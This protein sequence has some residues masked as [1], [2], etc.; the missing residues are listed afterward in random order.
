[1]QF[2]GPRRVVVA[3]PAASLSACVPGAG[4]LT[5]PFHVR[6]DSSPHCSPQTTIA[7]MKNQW[8][9]WFGGAE[10]CATLT[11]SADKKAIP[12]AALV[13]LL[14]ATLSSSGC[15]GLTGATKPASNQQSTPGAAAISVAPSSVSFGR[16]ALGSTASQSV[17]ISNGGGS[18]LT[19]T[20]ASTTAAGVNITGISLPIVI[21]AGKQSTFDVVFSPK[22]AGALSGNITVMSDLS[23][24]PSM[25]SL[26][27][28]GMA[29]TA[30]LT[31]SASSLSFGNVGVGKS[32]TLSVTLTNAGNSN[33][34]VSTVSVSGAR[35]STNGV[36][37]GLILAPGQSA[38]L[39][40]T[41]SPVA[42]GSLPGSVAVA[43]NA[44]NSPATI[45]LL[46]DGAA[47]APQTVSHSVSLT[48]T[49]SSSAVAGYDVYRS[50]VSGGPYS[51]LDSS[52]V[53]A[54]SYTDASVQAGLTYY[55]VVRSVTSAGVQ[56]ADSA[57]TSATI[58]T[59]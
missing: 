19:V 18:N 21:G 2:G 54:D 55:Y 28:T 25:V 51:I 52:I 34:T 31:T 20:Q 27:G 42:A 39:D 40:A 50:E 17:T 22:S 53:A 6:R 10:K 59:P 49:P 43:S 45:S 41:F 44:T 33:V 30:L 13:L 1:M 15:I 36:S 26:N 57:Q 9:K 47:T 3:R 24:S 7:A 38:T 12:F 4:Y 23:S 11:N 5:C 32:S 35:Y 8:M 48:W 16:V 58:P 37:A 56:S 46:G 14:F 29:A